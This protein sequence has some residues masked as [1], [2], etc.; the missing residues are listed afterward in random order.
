MKQ[1]ST[2]IANPCLS[3]N[4]LPFSRNG[5][6]DDEPLY[7]MHVGKISSSIAILSTRS[8]DAFQQTIR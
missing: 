5:I 2:F 1:I 4:N 6:D 8:Q 3:S 7:G